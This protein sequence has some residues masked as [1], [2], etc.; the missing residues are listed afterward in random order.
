V[1]YRTPRSFRK[2]MAFSTVVFATTL[3]AV[4][5]VSYLPLP[6]G[7]SSISLLGT[8]SAI[9]WFASA[10]FSAEKMHASPRHSALMEEHV[11][12]SNMIA[13]M[14]S[15]ATAMLIVFGKN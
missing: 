3:A 1:K 11:I 6:K 10:C 2:R 14:F 5:G 13:A 8:L 12:W 7:Y 4:V 15:S 9:C